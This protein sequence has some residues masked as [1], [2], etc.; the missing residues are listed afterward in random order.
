MFDDIGKIAFFSQ[1]LMSIITT[2]IAGLV[3][4]YMAKAKEMSDKQQAEYDVLVKRQQIE[5]D[6]LREGLRSLLRNELISICRK[7]LDKGALPLHRDEQISKLYQ[8]YH[9]LGGNGSVTR[10]VKDTLELPHE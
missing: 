2:V 4:R 9:G 8:A 10:L 1:L 5:N 7:A 3:T 6:A